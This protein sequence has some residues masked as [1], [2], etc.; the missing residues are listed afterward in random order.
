MQTLLVTL[1]KNY[2]PATFGSHLEFLHEMQKSI[3]LGNRTR[4]SDFDEIFE[5]QDICSLL[6]SFHQNCFPDTF[7]GRLEFLCRMR[8]RIYLR[9]GERARAIH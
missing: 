4:E 1:L 6:V 3:Y 9:N 5:P 2:F 8:K 7:D